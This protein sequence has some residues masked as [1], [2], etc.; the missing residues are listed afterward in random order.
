MKA[1]KGMADGR[2]LVVED[3]A[4]RELEPRFDLRRHSPT[5]FAW[6]YGGSGPAQ[7]ALAVACDVLENDQKALEIYQDLRKSW[8]SRL[9][10][11]SA[12][13]PI[14]ATQIQTLITTLSH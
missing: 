9:P 8:V 4:E 6:G 5:G 7:L 11:T 14:P 13:G 12:W 1:Y 10:E 3:G 2:V